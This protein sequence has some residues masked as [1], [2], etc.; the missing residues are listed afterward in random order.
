MMTSRLTSGSLWVTQ[1]INTEK[2]LFATDGA[3]RCHNVLGIPAFW[4]SPFP[5]P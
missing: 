4:A 3:Y 2:C 5:Y 1:A